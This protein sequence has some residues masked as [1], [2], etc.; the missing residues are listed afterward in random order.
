MEEDEDFL[1]LPSSRADKAADIAL[2]ALADLVQAL[3]PIPVSSTIGAFLARA[4]KKRLDDAF[5]TLVKLIESGRLDLRDEPSIEH[6]IPRAMVYFE[7]AERGEY[8]HNL[9]TLGML[10][11]CMSPADF[12]GNSIR[13]AA[14]RIE[15]MTFEQLEFLVLLNCVFAE[16]EKE[17]DHD[18]YCVIEDHDVVR[19]EGREYTPPEQRVNSFL[20]DLLSRGLLSVRSGPARVGDIIGGLNYRRTDAFFE[21]IDAAASTVHDLKRSG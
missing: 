16:K 11:A 15:A 5:E 1:S 12:G 14:R 4:K 2:A 21:I 19:F 10:L 17:I 3:M 20:A 13:Q 8:H 7:A 6:L 18:V 9:R